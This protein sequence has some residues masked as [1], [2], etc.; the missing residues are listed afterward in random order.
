M[1]LCTM[2][3]NAAS[4]E[5]DL[6]IAVPRNELKMI[7]PRYSNAIWSVKGAIADTIGIKVL[8]CYTLNV[9]FCGSNYVKK[10]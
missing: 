8:Y 9:K 2:C 7:V 10:N 4:I 1:S 3:T 5:R 6:W